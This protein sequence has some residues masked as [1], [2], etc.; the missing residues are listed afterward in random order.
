MLHVGLST[1]LITVA[2]LS[3]GVSRLAAQQPTPRPPA[4]S[5][6]APPAVAP[7]GTDAGV[8]LVPPRGTERIEADLELAKN[9]ARYTDADKAAALDRRSRAQAE[10]EVKKREISTIDAR[11]KL[12]DKEKNESQKASL[13]AE[14]NVAER[15][16]DLLERRADLAKSEVEVADKRAAF[17]RASRTAL[18]SE[19]DLARRRGERSRLTTPGP[20]ATHLD[21]MILELARKVLE[22]QRDRAQA[23]ADLAD[24]EKQLSERRLAVFRAQTAGLQK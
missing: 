20:E 7:Q 4:Q 12:A 5:A 9:D 6:V 8:S 16:K 23:E 21:Q 22:G 2:A 1:S 18:E 11:M 17:A 14:K 19:L 3:S 13:A 24:K 10:T 15:E